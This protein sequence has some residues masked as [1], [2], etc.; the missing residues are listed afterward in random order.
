MGQRMPDEPHVYG[1]DCLQCFDEGKTP[2]KVY[3]RFSL[4]EKCPDKPDHVCKIPPND[5]MF[6]LTQ[7][8]L[9]ACQWLYIGDEWEIHY[10]CHYDFPAQH[11]LD[12]GDKAGFGVFWH[13][14]DPCPAE[15]TVFDNQLTDCGE[16]QCG[17]L[18]IG[19]VTWTHQAT[20][21][22]AALNMKKARDLFL[23][24]RPLEDGNLVYKFCR[25]Q[26]ATNI[27]ILFEP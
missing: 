3:A 19:V 27:S 11:L 4:I 12:L 17:K 25:L 5:R 23:E 18:G 22:L 2:L 15:G 13:K 16:F 7:D 9:H 26:D 10:H 8:P 24:M 1:D 14:G 20:E 21:L 6:T